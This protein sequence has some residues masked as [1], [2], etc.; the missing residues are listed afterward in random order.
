MISLK[1]YLDSAAS[2]SGPRGDGDEQALLAVAIGVYK[3]TLVEIGNCSL[4][5]CPGL[6]DELKRRLGDLESGL[7]AKTNE[8]TL[9][10]TDANAR[11]QLRSWGQETAK[12]Y[13]QKTTEVKEL[14]LTIARTAESVSSRDQ[15][16]AGQMS[17]VTERLKAIASLEDL[18][19]IRASIVKSASDL[20]QSI[21]RM[22]AEGKETLDQLRSEVAT[23]QTKLEEAEAIAA[24]DR[25]TGLN[26]RLHAEGQVEKR[27]AAEN[28]FCVALIDL[29]G[30][31]MVNDEY[32]HLVGDELLKQFGAELTSRCRKTDVIGRWGGDEFI[33][34]FDCPLTEAG[35]RMERLHEWICGSYTVQ[36]TQGEFRVR[37]DVSVGLSEFSAGDSM[38]DLLERADAEMYKQKTMARTV[39]TGVKQS[40]A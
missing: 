35:P 6:G 17:E 30:F 16:S 2:G 21:D 22:T 23:Y 8:A 13:Q 34:L 11:S 19:A 32:G 18:T 38:K 9:T 31:K 1:R 29:D 3:S 37:V 7:S 36:G 40:A 15:R 39:K 24:C 28:P 25:L 33:L 27:I 5:A 14:L 4:A 10:V 12:H 20:K 26:S